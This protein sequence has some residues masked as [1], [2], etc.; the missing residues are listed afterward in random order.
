MHTLA[1]SNVLVFILLTLCFGVAAG[2]ILLAFA[3]AFNR[4]KRRGSRY[5]FREKSKTALDIVFTLSMFA[6]IIP[7]GVGMDV[8]DQQRHTGLIMVLAISAGVG[9]LV[10]VLLLMPKSFYKMDREN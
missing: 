9:G 6:S 3:R 5:P 10:T 4:L 8:I 7:W 1:T 2:T